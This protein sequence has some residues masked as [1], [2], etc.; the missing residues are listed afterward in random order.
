MDY[1]YVITIHT[2]YGNLL[3]TQNILPNTKL[4]HILVHTY[5]Y[6]N[7]LTNLL[8]YIQVIFKYIYII[9]NS[10]KNTKL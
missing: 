1:K 8:I 6:S 5:S 9:I 4:Q 10:Y 2:K 3:V 7:N